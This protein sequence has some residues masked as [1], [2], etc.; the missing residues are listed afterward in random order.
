MLL[1]HA[2]GL[3]APG[4][5]RAVVLVAASGTG[6]ST[7]SHHLARTWGYL[8][9]ESIG[10]TDDLR[11]LGHPKPVSRIVDPV[12]LSHK[13]EASPDDAGYGVAPTASVLGAV[14]LLR[15]DPDRAEPPSLSVAPLV[16]SVISAIGQ[17]SS[18]YLL[19]DPLDRLASALAAGGGPFVLD[20]RDIHDCD[21]L[22][23]GL[24]EDDVAAPERVWEH[25]PPTADERAAV[26]GELDGEAPPP[27]EPPPLTDATR[28][29]RG[30][31]TDAI[32]TG[33]EAVVLVG[34]RPFRL[35]G[36]GH[37]LWLALEEPLTLDD[38][39]EEVTRTLGEHPDARALTTNAAEQLVR[40]GLVEVVPA[41]G[42]LGG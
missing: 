31:W 35:G 38:A 15:R 13:E 11:A 36:V 18:L 28:L 9:D 32:A 10:I 23:E 30:P 1:L 34:D 33:D 7:A 21:A 39:I 8:S 25:L 24:L 41:S 42:R 22:L 20:Y 16:D 27:V 14:V 5:D 40:T 37:A 12:D 26:P 19:E 3:T 2:A 4:D 29:R 6:K 17:T